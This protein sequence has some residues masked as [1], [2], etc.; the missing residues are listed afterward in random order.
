MLQWLKELLSDGQK[1]SITR[2]IPFYFSLMF[3]FLDGFLVLRKW[4]AL[5]D[6]PLVSQMAFLLG[7]YGGAKGLQI[8][9]EGNQR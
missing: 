5:T 7:I 9:E 6:L 1:A 4:I 2:L 3:L 8:V